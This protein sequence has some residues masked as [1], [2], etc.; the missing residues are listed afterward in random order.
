MLARPDG[1]AN[2]FGL[3]FINLSYRK[4]ELVSSPDIPILHI[5]CHFVN[6]LPI[7]LS[8][9]IRTYGIKIVLVVVKRVRP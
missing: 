9:V 6:T 1:Q 7:G 4:L 8:W 2:V 5:F 3:L